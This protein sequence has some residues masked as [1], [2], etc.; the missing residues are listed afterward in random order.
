M[1]MTSLTSEP[2][3]ADRIR[4]AI[5]VSHPIQHFCP[6]YRSIAAD[7]R[8]DLLVIFAEERGRDLTPVSERSSSG[9]T[10]CSKVFAIR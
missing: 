7:P 3:L 4:L 1:S 5:V 6:M 10:I 9:R 8:V 2:H